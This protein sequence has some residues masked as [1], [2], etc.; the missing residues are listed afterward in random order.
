MS[1]GIATAPTARS[2][3]PA[4]PLLRGRSHQ[5]AVL[6]AI[7]AGIFLI[8]NAPSGS[9]RFATAVY[10]TTLIGLFA[11][12]AAYHRIN[13]SPAAL[14]WMRRLDHSMIYLFIAG[15]NTAYTILVLEGIWQW[16]L[17]LGVWAGAIVGITL[18]LVKFDGFARIGGALYIALGWI[19]VISLPQAIHNS[20][21]GPLLLVG[22]GGLMYTIGAVVLLRR[23]PDPSPSVFGYHEIWH[24]LVVAASAC[25]FTA[26]TM[27]VRS[28]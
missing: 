11:T 7:P 9:T 15:T 24:A 27:L 28:A 4:K 5:L 2:A 19:G 26:I 10:A 14:H 8:S 21:G 25:Q 12:S 20:D 23:R 18:K 3:A 16:V 6:A 22:V 1:E 17:L 13:W